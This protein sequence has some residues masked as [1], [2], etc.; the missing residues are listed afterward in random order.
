MTQPLTLESVVQ[1]QRN[2]HTTSE[3]YS[4][5]PTTHALSVLA[6]HG[7]LPA[8]AAEARVTKEENRG[9]QRHM[10]RLQNPAFDRDLLDVGDA[11][12]E[13]VLVNAHG[14]GAAFQ[15]YLAM[16]EKVCG[17]GLIVDR[18]VSD[19]YRVPHVGYTADKVGDA[20][21]AITDGFPKVFARRE[22]FKAIR[23]DR[24]EQHAYAK[25]AIELRFD[26][27]RYA[28]EP[29]EVLRARRW[30]Q[31]EPTLWN[32]FNAVQENVIRGGVRQRRGDGSRVRSRAVGSITE[33]VRLNR[34][35][36]RLTEEMAAIAH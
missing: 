15:L 26:G 34:A 16:L 24:D 22:E 29:S 5:I 28:V 4:F 23:L 30:Q 14:G 3:R 6:E 27:E 36:W 20:V 9:Y 7:W 17:N 33:N 18:G 31:A 11:Y 35:L 19:H 25:A 32:T 2:P 13:I 21:S 8:R 10:V 1:T 12:P